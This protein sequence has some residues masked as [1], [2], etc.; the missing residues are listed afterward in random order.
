MKILGINY[1]SEASVSLLDNG[2]I[3]FAI[4]E[5]R[6]NRIKNWYGSPLKSIYHTLNDNNLKI[7]NIFAYLFM[8]ILKQMT[9][10]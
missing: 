9:K 8:I 1:F 7:S 2:K 10:R 4:S 3:K 6:I 5:E